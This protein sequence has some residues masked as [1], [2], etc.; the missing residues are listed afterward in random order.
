LQKR[1]SD[2][3]C[4]WEEGVLSWGDPLP[5]SMRFYLFCK[6]YI[7]TCKSYIDDDEWTTPK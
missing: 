1:T 4:A 3:M 5:V 7:C 6:K 2:Q